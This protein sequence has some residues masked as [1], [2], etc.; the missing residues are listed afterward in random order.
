MRPLHS[1]ASPVLW[2]GVLFAALL[3][4]MPEMG[5][6][7]FPGIVAPLS[8]KQVQR[9]HLAQ[10]VFTVQRVNAETA[11]RMGIGIH[12]GGVPDQP[13]RRRSS[14]SSAPRGLTYT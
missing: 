1:I 10:F 14:A 2:V 13:L 3:F 9:K 5:F 6:G 12:T 11:L 7:T 4:G 8:A